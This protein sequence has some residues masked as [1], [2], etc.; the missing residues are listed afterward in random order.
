MQKRG[1]YSLLGF[2]CM[3]LPKDYVLS[4]EL[5][6][7]ALDRGVN[8]FDTAYMYQGNE[9]LLGRVLEESDRRGEAMIATKIQPFHVD[10][11]GDFEKRFQI[12]LERLQTDYID[13]YLMHM[14]PDVPTWERLKGIGAVEWLAEKKEKGQ[15]RKVG[16]S[17]HGKT[18]T[19]L[20]LLDL[21]PWDFCQVQ[22]NYMDEHSQAGKAGVHA[23]YE[24]GIEVIIMEPLRGGMLTEGLPPQAQELFAAT[25]ESPAS[26]GLR[27]LYAQPEVSCVLS[28]MTTREMLDENIAISEEVRPFGEEDAAV[29]EQ[30]Q[31][32]ILAANRIGCTGCSYCMPCPFGVDI[33]GAFRSYNASCSEG[34]IKGLTMYFMYTTLKAKRSHAG[35][36]TKCG[37]CVSKCPQN[38]A[39]PD[40][41]GA[42]RKR[43]ETPLYKLAT[44]FTKR[45][46]KG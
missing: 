29:I 18:E 42:V 38:I 12:Q 35:L 30:V 17:F 26:W 44:V 28:G 24:K 43:L 8:Y 9:A 32:A 41:L 20:E 11:P 3:R 46:Y 4:K 1:S 22:Y 2:G 39:I 14:L 33:P 19:F 7:H 5:L 40:E 36:C 27:W 21:Y 25:G 16:F 45:K 6:L 10:A 34:Y 23:A 31:V 37:L 15:I 13:N